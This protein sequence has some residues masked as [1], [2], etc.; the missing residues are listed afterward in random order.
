[1]EIGKPLYHLVSDLYEEMMPCEYGIINKHFHH[2][3]GDRIEME[4]WDVLDNATSPISRSS[5]DS[6]HVKSHI[7]VYMKSPG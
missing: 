4:I 7:S 1:M 5:H 3:V 6:I 2:T